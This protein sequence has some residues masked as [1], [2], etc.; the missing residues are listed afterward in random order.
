MTAKPNPS[1]LERVRPALVAVGVL[2]VLVALVNWG[3][4]TKPG[5]IFALGVGVLLGLIGV[6]VGLGWWL[7]ASP[8]P[9]GARVVPI[10]GA[11][12][13]R[14]LAAAVSASSGLL[15]VAGGLWDEIWH[16]RYGGFGNDFLW[17]PHLLLYSS[18]ALI[19]AL[20]AGAVLVLA[21]GFRGSGGLR[22]RMRAEPL[23]GVIALVSAYLIFSLPSDELWHRIYGR[24]ITAWS[25]PHVILV[26]GIAGVMLASLP[27]ALSS[28]PRRAG[29]FLEKLHPGEV[30][31]LVL[32]AWATTIFLQI[33]TAEWEGL[34]AVQSG[35]SDTFRNA[36]WQRP[37][38][39]YPVVI[40]SIALF[41][42]RV[43]QTALGRIGVASLVGLLVLGFRVGMM[44]VNDARDVGLG[45]TPHLLILPA[46]FALDAS[47]WFLGTRDRSG[48]VTNLASVAVFLVVALSLLPTLVVYPRVNAGTLPGMIGMGLLMG[49]LAGAAGSSLG[50]M[51]ARLGARADSS[52]AEPRLEQREGLTALAG[53]GLAVVIVLVSLAVAS[54]P[55]R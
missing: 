44:A 49:V 36:F 54:P 55:T 25:L 41:C 16:R 18:I 33:G 32:V 30:V 38:W 11:S 10:P 13:V 53:L 46:M 4:T 35:S 2:V 48:V 19:A 29:R 47:A 42:G 45:I 31:A 21:L 52:A 8:L 17:P 1:S 22:E 43:I 34:R 50:G 7:L 23:L 5:P 40:V 3:G 6:F 15:F 27:L 51:L 24:D 14:A 20:A 12:R 9:P 28:V 26:T 37:E 39:L